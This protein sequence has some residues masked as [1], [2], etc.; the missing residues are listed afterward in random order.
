[1]AKNG[2]N[3]AEVVV[4][5]ERVELK[6]EL[7][8]VGATSMVVGIIIGSGIFVSPKGVIE[9][10]GSI[11]LC[12]IVWVLA[13]FIS[14]GSA[15]CHA[16]LSTSL[17][18]SGGTYTYLQMGVG[19]YIAFTYAIIV[20]LIQ[21]PGILLIELMTLCK[22]LLSITATCGIP[23]YLE[24]F[25]V[26]LLVVTL[27]IVNS[28]S[29]RLTS[30][31]TIMTTIGKLLAL[32][33]IITGVTSELG[34]GFQGTSNKPSSL[35]L[36]LYSAIWATSGG[37]SIAVVVEEI[38]NPSKTIPRS[39][40]IGHLIVI[41]VYILTNISYLTVM[42]KAEMIQSEA[43]AVDTDP[44]G[45]IP[46]YGYTISRHTETSRDFCFKAEKYGARTYYFMTDSRDQMTG[47]VA[48]LTE[49][50]ARSKKR[51]VKIEQ[52]KVVLKRELGLVG[53][54]SLVVGTII[55]AGIFISPKGVLQNT[56]SVGL[57]LVV[58]ITAGI[59]SLGS[60]LCSAELGA[61][62]NL[63]GGTYTYIRLGLGNLL[64]FMFVSQ[65][66]MVRNSLSLLIQPL[67]FSKYTASIL[68]ICG[69]PKSLEKMIAA[70]TL[71]TLV[72]VNMYSSRLAGRL[73]ILTT[74]GKVFALLV[75]IVGGLFTIS[76]GTTH[77]LTSGF[78]G[79]KTDPSSI[80]LAFY[81]AL[82][83]YSGSS[84]INNL[85]EEIKSPSKNIP[86]AAIFG[87][88][89][90]IGI[91]VLTNVS[92]L[93]V[94]TRSELLQANAVAAVTL[95]LLY[96]FPSDLS[97]LINLV[98]F[99]DAL[100]DAFVYLSLIRFRL[101]TMKDVP[102]TVRVPLFIP[103]LMFL[104]KVYLFIAPIIIRPR[105]EYIYVGAGVATCSLL[106]YIPFVYFQF[107]LPFYD[108]IVMWMQL[109][110]EICPPSQ[111]EK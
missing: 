60:S 80:A 46:L 58:W 96:L 20:V 105:L 31:V 78:S 84:T 89:S 36:A 108:K 70:T 28:Y 41:V 82:W 79:T 62:I 73:T 56:G 8:L 19:N 44:L 59:I 107:R 3:K 104:V 106:L 6:R 22:N 26:A 76:Q 14:L 40:I 35:A 103:V 12:F 10:T 45:A 43:V 71:V 17:Q 64:A 109:I 21:N 67:T 39:V 42:T 92:Y 63:S 88:V 23:V 53:A 55:G 85:V 29:S 2:P 86:R 101:W 9:S 110:F 52:E 33:T 61:M 18:K 81:S 27:I 102:R 57:C 68:P 99:L 95:S 69:S 4:E 13:G 66:I 47:W 54:T 90:I 24:R 77:E 65:R 38:K 94:M 83:A 30:K 32:M 15:L 75:I 34:T 50:A 48:A 97:Q 100:Y 111:P 72:M 87:I 25:I 1:M 7:G 98:G 93:A 49:A 11:A 51:T 74:V 91:Y 37:E 16:E 5:T